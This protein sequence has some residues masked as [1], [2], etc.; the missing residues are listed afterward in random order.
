MRIAVD[1]MGG[2]HGPSVVIAGVTQ[3]LSSPGQERVHSLFVVGRED[4]IKAAMAEHRC[5]DPRIEVVHASQA[6]T[7]EDNPLTAIRKKKDASVV[8]A[9]ALVSDGKADA[10][11]SLETRE[12]WSPLR[13][14]ALADPMASSDR[15]LRP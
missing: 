15:R 13:H 5:A 4:E 11:I 8:R 10:V 3:A 1:V 6:L 7:M 9:V 14:S 12:A 2:D